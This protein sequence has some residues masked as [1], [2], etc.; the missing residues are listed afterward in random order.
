MHSFD[1]PRVNGIYNHDN[2]NKLVFCFHQAVSD[3]AA[4]LHQVMLVFDASAAYKQDRCCRG[5]GLSLLRLAGAEHAAMCATHGLTVIAQGNANS[6]GLWLHLLGYSILCLPEESHYDQAVHGDLFALHH[7]T[8]AACSYQRSQGMKLCLES[9]KTSMEPAFVDQ[10][11]HAQYAFL[12]EM[13]NTMC[14]CWRLLW[15]SGMVNR[16]GHELGYSKIG[17]GSDHEEDNA[18][19]LV[20]MNQPTATSSSA[21]FFDRVIVV[22]LE[23][24]HDAKLIWEDRQEVV[25]CN[26]NAKL[27]WE[28]RQEVVACN[29]LEDRQEVVACNIVRNQEGESSRMGHHKFSVGRQVLVLVDKVPWHK[30]VVGPFVISRV[31]ANGAVTIRMSPNTTKRVPIRHM[32]LYDI[33][34]DSDGAICRPNSCEDDLACLAERQQGHRSEVRAWQIDHAAQSHIVHEDEKSRKQTTKYESNMDSIVGQV[35]GRVEPS[36]V[37]P[38]TRVENDDEDGANT[39]PITESTRVKNDDEDGANTWPIT[40]STGVS[41][42][43]S[44]TGVDNVGAYNDG[45]FNWPIK[46]LTGKEEYY[47]ATVPIEER[48]RVEDDDGAITWPIADDGATTWP[49]AESAG[50]ENNV[51]SAGVDNV[52]SAG[53]DNIERAGVDNVGTTGVGRTGVEDRN[54]GANNDAHV[55]RSGVAERVGS[56][57]VDNIERAGVDNVGTTGVGRTGVED[58]NT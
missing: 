6:I 26:I 21:L 31:H 25:A 5:D 11:C 50:L 33:S 28:D 46:E 1:S 27:I 7:A 41:D 53:V 51:I 15:A 14:C 30:H 4:P 32:R 47:G 23:Q 43:V 10:M 3:D 57:G 56:A 44:S 20:A 36:D 17:A 58:R 52:G 8:F 48:T 39:W 55:G 49:I 35:V 16:N 2:G 42:N 54:T 45:A 18:A 34:H 13:N 12:L 9:Q 29:S 22:T 38:C 37:Q 19:M 40:E 24:A